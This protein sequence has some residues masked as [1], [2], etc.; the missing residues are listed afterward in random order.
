[1]NYRHAFHA[2]NVADVL[3][4]VVLLAVI[5]HLQRKPTPW[6]ALDSHAGRGSYRLSNP[7]KP[8]EA[9]DGIR[10]LRQRPP[11]DPLLANYLAAV[12]RHDRDTQGAD[13][14]HYPGSPSL[15]ADR[16]GPDDRLACCEIQTE[17]AD[18]LSQRFARDRRVG[19]HRRDGYGAI[20]AL[21]PPRLG[22]RRFA[23]G[24]VLIDPPYE[25]RDEEFDVALP[26]LADGLRRW[27]QGV[28]MLW[29]PIKLASTLTRQYRRMAALPAASALRIELCVRPA[30]SPLRLNGSG[31]VVCNPPWG[32]DTALATALPE[33]ATRLDQGKGNWR[34]DWL[35]AE[36][37]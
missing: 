34:L 1:M 18:A 30:D 29:Y 11:S 31:L 32:L 27:P 22:E 21:L 14:E 12:A 3:K 13:G 26:A 16:L 28:F 36:R 5:D 9:D 7:G 20:K 25:T 35:I 24:L 4:H 2:G 8:S 10:R 37:T 15:I 23:R 33:L 19:V 6:F 17:E